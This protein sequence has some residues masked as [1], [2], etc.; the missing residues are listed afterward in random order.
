MPE[1]QPRE[2]LA[3]E[4]LA[5]GQRAEH[6]H[7]VT[8]QDLRD[9]AAVSGDR[10]PLHLDE[11][12]AARTLFK[13]RVAHGMLLGAYISAVLGTELPGPGA[14]YMSQ[15]LRFRRPVRIGDEVT[16]R[17]TVEEIEPDTGH[18]RLATVCLVRNKPVADGEALVRVSSRAAVAEAGAASG[19][20]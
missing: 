20:D 15:S 17:V 18:V 7:R 5:V 16:T 8:D 9:F 13:G 14:I 12:F 1:P 2:G 4:D 11:A 6:V 3:L 10:N 19:A